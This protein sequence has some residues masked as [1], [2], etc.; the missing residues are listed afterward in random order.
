MFRKLFYFLLGL[1]GFYAKEEYEEEI[2]VNPRE[3]LIVY[4]YTPDYC[5]GIYRWHGLHYESS[6]RSALPSDCIEN[7]ERMSKLKCWKSKARAHF[8]V[9]D[10]IGILR[11]E[12]PVD[13]FKAT[14][15]VYEI[16]L[17]LIK[18]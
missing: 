9:E 4:P 18:K 11:S 14:I 8:T 7:L 2:K 17:G 15:K 5:V 10:W 1:T 13:Y 12:R 16:H 3:G 6:T